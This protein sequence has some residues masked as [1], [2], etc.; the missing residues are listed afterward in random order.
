MTTTSTAVQTP[1]SECQ[2]C[3]KPIRQNSQG[4]WGARKRDDPHP[5]YC[6]GNQASKRHEPVAA[7]SPS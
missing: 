7:G 6:G 4:I 1:V 3:R 5:W 2:H